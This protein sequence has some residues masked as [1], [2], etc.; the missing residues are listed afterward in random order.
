MSWIPMPKNK[1]GNKKM[2]VKRDP[3]LKLKKVDDKIRMPRPT[4]IKEVKKKQEELTFLTKQNLISVVEI[5]EKEIPKNSSIQVNHLAA[6]ATQKN[7]FSNTIE[8]ITFIR[9]FLPNILE[10]LHK[11][12]S[13]CSIIN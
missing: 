4:T 9:V 7:I 2:K 5:I 6:I 3:E 8:A 1:F 11:R 10:I 12:E 13:S